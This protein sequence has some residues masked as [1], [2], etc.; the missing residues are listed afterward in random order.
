MRKK[1]MTI[2]AVA[3]V[4]VIGLSMRIYALSDF[5]ESDFV[6]VNNPDNMKKIA[7]KVLKD[8]GRENYISAEDAQK[9]TVDTDDI[10]G[11]GIDDKVILINFGP[12]LSVIAVYKG[13]GD[14]YTYLGEIGQLNNVTAFETRRLEAEGRDVISIKEESSQRLGAYELNT[15]VRAYLWDGEKF[16]NIV[17]LPERIET[18]WNQQ[19][20]GDGTG[21]SQWNRIRENSVI[22]WEG[23]ENPI[24]HTDQR[25]DYLVS[26]DTES[27]TVPADNTYTLLSSVQVKQDL[28]WSREFRAFILGVVQDKQTGERFGVL[29]DFNKSVYYPVPEYEPYL[30]KYRVIDSK[31]NVFVKETNTLTDIT[32]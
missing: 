9:I 18:D 21:P 12:D 15:F 10:D 1:F 32:Q 11:D 6:N 24:I 2:A 29:E 7:E 30:N 23:I 22:T 13:N 5:T 16:I 17:N 25:Q 14:T 3:A 26:S 20:D 19:W 31:G 4:M 8:I 28:K 27:K